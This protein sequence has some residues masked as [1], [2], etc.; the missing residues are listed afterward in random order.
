MRTA[1]TAIVP[2]TVCN[3][4]ALEAPT[5]GAEK[6]T[7]DEI[8]S[9]LVTAYSGFRAAVQES[10]RRPMVL[11]TGFW[12]CGAYGGDRELMGVLQLLAARAAGVASLRFHAFDRA[13]VQ[14][15]ARALRVTDALGAGEV[16]T[17]SIIR[18]LV[19]REYRWGVSDGN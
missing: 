9:I 15:R 12:G 13:G 8:S 3:I 11:H 1:T 14:V 6:Y 18:S 5:G 16:P 17:E 19:A 10:R 4:I 7:A 2:P